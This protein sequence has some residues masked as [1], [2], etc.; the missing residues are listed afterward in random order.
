MF[1]ELMILL[2]L[3]PKAAQ[4]LQE[5]TRWACQN[6]S[7]VAVIAMGARCCGLLRRES[8]HQRDYQNVSRAHAAHMRL[9]EE[10]MHMPVNKTPLS[11][12]AA[13]ASACGVLDGLAEL[14][15]NPVSSASTTGCAAYS[16]SVQ[17]GCGRSTI[18]ITNSSTVVL[19]LDCKETKTPPVYIRAGQKFTLKLEGH[20]PKHVSVVL[21]GYMAD[22]NT[23]D[24][25][26]TLDRTQTMGIV[27]YEIDGQVEVVPVAVTAAVAAPGQTA[28]P[29]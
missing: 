13:H 26:A 12:Y 19:R 10:I 22:Y 15:A 7:A 29:S 11:V 16:Y 27:V 24:F 2:M 28:M 3:L 8:W 14:I 5:L 18:C 9:Y 21:E 20:L 23:V 1:A 6:M 4:L 17:P 25:T